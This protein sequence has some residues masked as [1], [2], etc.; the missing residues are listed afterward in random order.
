MKCINFDREFERYLSAWMKAHAG[1]YKDADALEDAAPEVYQAFLDTPAPW[2]DGARPGAYFDAFD[3][4]AQLVDWLEQYFVQ[5]VPAPDMLLNRIAALGLSAEKPLMALLTKPDASQEIRLTAVNLLREIDSAA[6]IDLYVAWQAARRDEADELA[7][8]AL[9]SLEALGSRA[10]D[11]M[12]KA[13]PTATPDGQ[14]ALLS[15]LSEYP[16][17]DAV[18]DIALA[19]FQARP[20]R[21]VVLADCLGRL[22]DERALPALMA[23]AASEETPYL[24]YIELRNAIERLGGEAPE[25]VFDAVDPAY[26]AMRGKQ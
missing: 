25:R 2:L 23:R 10:M 5:R 24:D 26:E 19:L 12:R 22:G 8:S 20:D 11:A 16:G 9:V 13:L 4:A 6:P 21:T 15:L 7:D 14:E 3:D 1:E 17:D 18:F